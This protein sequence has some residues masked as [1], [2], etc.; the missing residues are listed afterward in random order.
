M[1]SALEKMKAERLGLYPQITPGWVE[2]FLQD[3]AYSSEKAQRELGY[4]VTPLKEGVRMTY[5]WILERRRA[6]GK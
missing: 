2:T 5:E 6:R 3:W 4:T 1:Y